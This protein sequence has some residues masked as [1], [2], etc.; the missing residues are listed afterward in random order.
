MFVKSKRGQQKLSKIFYFGLYMYVTFPSD[1]LWQYLFVEMC[2]T[3]MQ[4]FNHTCSIKKSCAITSK[5]IR[6]KA[7]Y[8]IQLISKQ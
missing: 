4:C 5:K 6:A 1:Y 7:V 3:S 2:N 8:D